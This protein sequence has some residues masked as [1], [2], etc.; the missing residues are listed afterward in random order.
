MLYRGQWV[1]ADGLVTL[2]PSTRFRVTVSVPNRDQKT[3]PFRVASFTGALRGVHGKVL[4]VVACGSWDARDPRKVHVF[5]T[6]HRNLEP[7]EVLQRF[8][9]RWKI[10]TIFHETKDFLGF[11]PYQVRG[12]LGIVRHWQLVLIAH[13][14]LHLRL[15]RPTVTAGP[16]AKGVPPSSV[17]T[18]GDAL[19]IHRALQDRANQRWKRQNPV[20]YRLIAL[21]QPF[22]RVTT[23]AA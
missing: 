1:R 14:Y 6:S 22:M 2:I 21:T 13:T 18:L 23:R 10:E 9:L 20:L 19:K 16:A 11:D 15:G 4:I 17:P 3:R 5:A 7:G 8:A 12:W